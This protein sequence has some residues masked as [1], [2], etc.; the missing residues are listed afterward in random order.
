LVVVSVAWVAWVSNPNPFDDE[1]GLLENYEEAPN[2][3]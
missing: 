2:V 1:M 3:H